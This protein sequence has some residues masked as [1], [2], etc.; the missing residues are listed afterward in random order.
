M[1]QLKLVVDERGGGLGTTA[2][3]IT[4]G[5]RATE[6]VFLARGT[7]PYQ[8]ALGNQAAQAANLPLST[9]IP[10]YEPAR[11]SHLG[12]ASAALPM[13]ASAEPLAPAVAAT[14]WKRIGLW[15]VLLLGVG[16]LV[17]MAMSLLRTT[18]AKP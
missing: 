8:L 2:P 1:Q 10:G 15:A 13:A 5:L 18:Q 6:L 4:V 3:Q 11:L 14:D 16:L 17:L 9:L 7:P 12:V